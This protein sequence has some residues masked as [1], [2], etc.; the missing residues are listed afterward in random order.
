MDQTVHVWNVWCKDQKM[1]RIFRYHNASIKDVR[2]SPEGFSLLSCGYDCASRLV[3]VEKGLETQFFKEDQVVETVRF[4]P[5]NSSLFLSGGSKGILRLWDTRC[6]KVLHEYVKGLGPILDIEF[7]ADGKH[8]IS[9]TDTSKSR[10][11]E[12]SIIIWDVSRQVPLSNQV[13]F[14]LNLYWKSQMQLSIVINVIPL[15]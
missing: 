9:S 7:S 4:H 8:F 6:S 2:W 1:G 5:S 14:N 12:D 13:T 11:S 10:I 3:D 15:Y